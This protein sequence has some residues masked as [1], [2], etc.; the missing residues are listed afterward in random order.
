MTDKKT[1]AEEVEILV[2]EMTIDIAGRKVTMREPSWVESL[3]IEPLLAPCVQYVRDRL[4][5]TD[6]KP[7]ASDQFL[8][9]L[10]DMMIEHYEAMLE[11]MIRC[12]DVDRE[13]VSTLKDSEGRKFM[14]LFWRVNWHF[15][16]RRL[17][18][19]RVLGRSSAQLAGAR[20]SAH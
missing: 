1:A 12:A 9:I 13:W 3:R 6:I 5:G 20:S 17:S 8:H 7:E 16:V 10:L 18:L 4:E 11:V 15:F 14:L 19:A 2:P